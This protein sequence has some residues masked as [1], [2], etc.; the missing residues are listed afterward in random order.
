MEMIGSMEAG[1][2]AVAIGIGATAVMD[3]GGFALKRLGGIPSP[4]YGLVGR[5]IA[6][7]PRGR[8]RHMPV[9]ASPPI[10]GERI[11]GWS[12]HYAI[13]IAFAAILLSIWGPGW[14]LS[15]TIGPALIVGLGSVA[16]PLFVMQPGMGAG[17][18]SRRTPNP[19]AARQRS[20]VNHALFAAGLYV[21]GWLARPLLSM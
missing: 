6:Y 20:L 11:V 15:P 19:R 5:W 21:A 2:S 9:A 4:N 18:A 14:A 8:F 13:G 10:R 3:M 16:A 12:A 17:L 1:M 7:M